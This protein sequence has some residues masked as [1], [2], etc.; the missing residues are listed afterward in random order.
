MKNWRKKIEVIAGGGGDWDSEQELQAH[1]SL[2]LFVQSGA[3][4][5]FLCS[6]PLAPLPN[7]L[8]HLFNQPITTPLYIVMVVMTLL[9]H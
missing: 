4:S 2:S 9:K 1:L 3:L 7:N 6:L 5:P 8:T